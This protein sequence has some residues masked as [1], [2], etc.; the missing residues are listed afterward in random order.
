MNI[1]FGTFLR[2]C[3]FN[4]HPIHLRVLDFIHNTVIVSIIT[5]VNYILHITH[6]S[7]PQN[8]HLNIDSQNHRRLAAPNYSTT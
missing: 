1:R 4:I 5:S 8:S 2:N 7:H 3:N 6:P